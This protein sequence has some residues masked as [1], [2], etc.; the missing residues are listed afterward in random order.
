MSTTRISS[1][2]L[3]VLRVL[4]ALKGHS[5][6]GLSNSDLAKALNESPATINRCCNTLIAEGLAIQLETGR[7][8]LSVAALQIAQ[9]HSTEMARASHRID[10]LT[11]RVAAGFQ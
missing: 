8:A 2:G 3:K 7:Y 6:S 9:A 4:K 10:E 1:S 11:Q 5:L